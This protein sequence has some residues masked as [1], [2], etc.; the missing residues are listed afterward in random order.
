[1]PIPQ[2]SRW[3][4]LQLTTAGQDDLRLLIVVNTDR[5]NFHAW[6]GVLRDAR[7]YVLSAFEAHAGEPGLHCH[8]LCGREL[9]S[10]SGSLRYPGIMRAPRPRSAHRRIVQ[11][12]CEQ[13]AWRESLKFYRVD[14]RPE[15]ALL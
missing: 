2:G 5:N 6:L 12:W 13:S 7:L 14:D 1:M 8:A 4:C 10:Y 11:Q 3:R 15:G 9:P